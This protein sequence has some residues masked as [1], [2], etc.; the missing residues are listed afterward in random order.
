MIFGDLFQYKCLHQNRAHVACYFKYVQY[1]R[2]A[3]LAE[4]SFVGDD[5]MAEILQN[6]R[7]MKDLKHGTADVVYGRYKVVE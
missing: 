1:S 3:Y 6:E 5:E 7:L 2:M 4:E